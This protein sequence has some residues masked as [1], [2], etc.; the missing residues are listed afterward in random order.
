MR[1]RA[2]GREEAGLGVSGS[3]LLAST[4]GWEARLSP[5]GTRGPSKGF[6]YGRGIMEGALSKGF[7]GSSAK[8]TG[9]SGNQTQSLSC[10]D[11]A[12]HWC[13]SKCL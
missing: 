3:T 10:D 12:Q 13:A 2:G 9:T 5:G 6:E 7:R 4:P 1:T 8:G 11:G